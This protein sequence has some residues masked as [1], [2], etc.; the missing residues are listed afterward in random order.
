MTPP[1]AGIGLISHHSTMVKN[2]IQGN[3]CFPYLLKWSTVPLSLIDL[4]FEDVL[5]EGVLGDEPP[6]LDEVDEGCEGTV[7][8]CQEVGHAA[9]FS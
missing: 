9:D 7:Q 4:S 1:P 2:L 5:D 6:L 8:R 3:Y